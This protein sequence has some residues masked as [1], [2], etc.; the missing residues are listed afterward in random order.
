MTEQQEIENSYSVEREKTI[1]ELRKFL[2]DQEE[3][4]AKFEEVFKKNFKRI[5]A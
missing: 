3:V 2:E 1:K 5:L 4:P